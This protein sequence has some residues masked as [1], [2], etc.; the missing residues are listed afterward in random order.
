[1]DLQDRKGLDLGISVGR[2]PINFQE[3][4]LINDFVDA[5]GITQNNLRPGGVV[6]L[7]FTGLYGWNQINRNTPSDLFVARNLEGDRAHLLGGFTE[8]DWR[9]TTA[10]FDVVYVRGGEFNLRGGLPVVP[11]GTAAGDEIYAG[12]S[13][14][15]RPGS[16]AVNVGLRAL[17][18]I[19]VGDTPS[20]GVLGGEGGLVF[21]NPAS[22]G[23]I[24]F[25]EVSWTPHHTQNFFYGNTFFAVDNYRAAAL[26]PTI[27][28]PLARA[29]ILFA[30]PGLGNV[31]GAFGHHM[32]FSDTRVCRCLRAPG[33]RPVNMVK[34]VEGRRKGSG[35]GE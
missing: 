19:P 9:S 3:G 18:S 32:F 14:V 7:R 16:G 5:V 2:Q 4:L 34:L 11:A 8:I 10:A 24:V 6:N 13:V 28:G 30:G 31:G 15:G 35:S 27:P 29:G 25:S 22:R 17:T 23:S 26:D 33:G 20:T 1:M 12:V 21:G